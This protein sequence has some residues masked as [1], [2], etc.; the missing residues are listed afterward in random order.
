MDTTT[1]E[2]R[3]V[4][5]DEYRT[6]ATIAPELFDMDEIVFPHEHMKPVSQEPHFQRIWQ[7][8]REHSLR[9]RFEF[10]KEQGKIT[11]ADA[12]AF[13]EFI[14]LAGFPSVTLYLIGTHYTDQEHLKEIE[15]FQATKRVFEA[16]QLNEIPIDT[17]SSETPES[18]FWRQMDFLFELTEEG[19]MEELPYFITDPRQQDKVN[20]IIEG[21]LQDALPTEST[22]QLA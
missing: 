15:G 4:F 7:Y 10:L 13:E 3:K 16:M 6:V 9:L 14:N 12:D 22:R 8:Y 5:E 21:R 17:N 11:E 1:E 18:Q 19:L 20:A 2:G